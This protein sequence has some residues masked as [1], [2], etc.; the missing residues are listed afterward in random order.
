LLDLREASGILQ[1]TGA[2]E[3]DGKQS[4]DESDHLK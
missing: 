3:N 4:D 2:A 1:H